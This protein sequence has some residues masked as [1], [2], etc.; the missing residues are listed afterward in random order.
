[1]AGLSLPKVLKLAM[2]DTKVPQVTSG[3]LGKEL[4]CTYGACGQQG[5]G[6]EGVRA[7]GAR[8]VQ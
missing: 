8:K 1:M 5:R 4:P 2:E 7:H 3:N 6:T